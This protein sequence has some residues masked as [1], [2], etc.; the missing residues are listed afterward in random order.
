M[1]EMF[2]MS[3]Q[4]VM[5]ICGDFN[6]DLLNP[7]NQ[8]PNEDF[9][10]TMYSLSLYPKI[11]RPSRITS[12]CATLIDNIF[13]NNTENNTISGLLINDIRN[14]LPV[15]TV[16]DNDYKKEKQETKFVYRRVQ[17]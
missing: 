3:N 15:F 14:H 8:K 7:N 6:I 1:E 17:Q 13:M 4:K 12:H 16:F 5:F 9:I 11:T 2:T 10:N